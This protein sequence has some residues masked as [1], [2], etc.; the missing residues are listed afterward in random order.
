MAARIRVSS[1][2]CWLLSRGTF[3]S[4]RTCELVNCVYKAMTRWNKSLLRCC[5]TPGSIDNLNNS[6]N[7]SQ[8]CMCADPA[9]HFMTVVILYA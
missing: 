1:V 2:I 9:F 8:R 3:K 6:D 7:H 4:A 5:P